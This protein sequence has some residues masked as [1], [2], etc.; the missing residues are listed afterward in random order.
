MFKKVFFSSF[1]LIFFFSNL[2]ANEVDLND[3]YYKIGW[4]NLE[5]PENTS[6]I[7]PDANASIEII[8]TEIYL[9]SKENIKKRLDLINEQQT[10]IEDIYEKLI[11]FDREEYYKINIEYNDAGYITSDRFKNFTSSNLLETMNKRMS[12]STS[13]VSW[14]IEPSLSENNLS[15]YAY[16]IEWLDG[17]ITYEYKSLILGREGYIE[18]TIFLFGDG[19]ELEDFFDYYS[20]VIK[21]IASTVKFNETYSY[22]DYQQ[23][24]YVSVNTLTNLIDKSYGR[25]IT[26]DP[27]SYIAFCLITT[28]DLKTSKITE[29][30][31]PRFAG[32]VIN[33]FVSDVK[34]EIADISEEDE[35]NVLSGMYGPADKQTFKKTEIYTNA[36]SA[37][38]T[39]IIEVTGDKE[40]DKIKYEYKNKLQFENGKPVRLYA[41]IDQT[42][43]SISK[44]TL[45]LNCRDYDYT[46]EEKLEAKKF[47]P[48]S[49]LLK[50]NTNGTPEY[51]Q[52]LVDKIKKLEGDGKTEKVTGNKNIIRN[53]KKGRQQVN[54]E[55]GA[56]NYSILK[57]E[58]GDDFMII[59]IYLNSSSWKGS[60]VYDPKS[61][62]S[63]FFEKVYM[64]GQRSK[65]TSTSIQPNKFNND[66]E[67]ESYL[68]PEYILDDFNYTFNRRMGDYIL[69]FETLTGMERITSYITNKESFSLATLLESGV[70]A[71]TWHAS[72]YI[73]LSDIDDY[74]QLA[75][76]N[77]STVCKIL[78][79]PLLKDLINKELNTVKIEEEL[80]KKGIN[81][82][83]LGCK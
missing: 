42:G 54:I 26:T 76:N 17:D 48:N 29:A 71:G 2:N 75:K 68:S 35:V 12:D 66:G 53:W 59:Y 38:Y 55:R 80:N 61:Q 62:F 77:P 7:I 36:Y 40:G 44:W 60:I 3:P 13:K 70:G 22:S 50:G 69:N 6:I 74:I 83:N 56:L 78:W 20:G 24:D 57:E 58:D 46:A 25:G 51:F 81:K 65:N 47:I 41:Y 4:K 43:F 8:E 67:L 30:D 63:E 14:L 10:N 31:Y 37:A 79:E 49:N 18:L 82:D 32:K 28:S 23:D 16:K 15:T 45:K 27:T 11:I 52:E 39:N 34:Q 5:N 73:V 72:T 64:A 33:F 1:F 19:N 21:E 9:D